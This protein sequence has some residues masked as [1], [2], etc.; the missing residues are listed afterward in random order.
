MALKP[1]DRN[2]FEMMKQYMI[3][4]TEQFDVATRFGVIYS[5]DLPSIFIK[6]DSS[7]NINSLNSAINS[8]QYI[9]AIGSVSTTFDIAVEHFKEYSRN[10]IPKVYLQLLSLPADIEA[11]TEISKAAL[12]SDIQVFTIKFGMDAEQTEVDNILHVN[13][14]SINSSLGKL[15]SDI[16]NGEF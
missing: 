7:N 4:V 5:S 14:N 10:G 16:C 13:N 9:P 3:G 12:D 15:S 8:I 2:N 1:S 6:L 11:T